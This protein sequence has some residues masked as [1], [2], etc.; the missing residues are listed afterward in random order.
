MPVLP[1]ALFRAKAREMLRGRW[2][3]ALLIALAVNLPGLLVQAVSAF[4]GVD[5]LSR[6]QNLVILAAREGRM[7]ERYLIT[8][9]QKILSETGVRLSL[10][11]SLL[12][13]LITPCLALGMTWWLISRLRG[14]EE[15]F[16]AVFSR[17]R[18]AHKAVGLHVMKALILLAWMIPGIIVM[19]LSMLPSMNAAPASLAYSAVSGYVFLSYAGMLLMAVLGIQAAL[20]LAMAEK[21]LA[22]HPEKKVFACLR[23]SRKLMNRRKGQLFSLELSFIFWYLGEML[24]ASMLATMGSGILSLMFQMLMSLFLS[25]Y[26]EGSVCVFYEAVRK[27]PA[28][29]ADTPVPDPPE[30]EALN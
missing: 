29:S 6:V 2:Q 23:E 5:P 30:D 4:S 16:S 14:G 26:M 21:I 22:D 18:V 15:G 20:R 17:L 11:A 12:A 9:M 1:S 28:A 24:V 8:G 7:T 27:L 3:T 13:W 25:V 19:T 10:G